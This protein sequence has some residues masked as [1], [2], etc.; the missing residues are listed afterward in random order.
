MLPFVGRAR[1]LGFQVKQIAAFPDLWQ[2]GCSASADVTALALDHVRD[3]EQRRRELDEM[4]G[5][6]QHLAQHGHGDS[7][8]DCPIPSDLGAGRGATPVPT[9]RK[10][11]R[12]GIVVTGRAAPH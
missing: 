1:D 8:P 4:I 6:L 7:R 10:A 12:R 9:A 5:T 2:D 11:P 3:P